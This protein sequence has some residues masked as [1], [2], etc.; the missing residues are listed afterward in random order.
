MAIFRGAG[1]SSIYTLMALPRG[2]QPE[3]FSAAQALLAKK[4]NPS[5]R[6]SELNAIH[7]EL[8]LPRSLSRP[9]FI[10]QLTKWK[11]LREVNLTSPYE[12]LSRFLT[13]SATPYD[14]AVSLRQG[15]YLSHQ[16]A[17]ELHG[18]GGAQHSRIF[19]N[20]EQSPKPQTEV[21]SQES[22]DRAFAN[23]QRRSK[24]VYTSTVGVFVLLSGKYTGRLGVET[25]QNVPVTIL[26][27]TLIDT[28]VRPYYA[29]GPGNVLK[30]YKAAADRLSVPTLTELLQKMS[31]AY[32]Y[33]QSIGF[34]LQ[35]AGVPGSQL[36]PLRQLGLRFKFYLDYGEKA[37]DYDDYWRVYYPRTL[38]ACSYEKVQDH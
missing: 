21:T 17:L 3:W 13:A 27:R 32:P 25:R 4:G 16:S 2:S 31:F 8:R 34:Y 28:A 14:V 38:E 20:K 18:I 37:L 9:E 30:A 1:P 12:E 29:G 5:F 23:A 36:E 19:V 15:S 24:N 26:E 22:I 10:D 33:H 11:V 35:R 6:A 7:D